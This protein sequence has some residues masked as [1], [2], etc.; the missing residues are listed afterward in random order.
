MAAA[1]GMRCYLEA[2]GTRNKALYEHLGYETVD[3][4]GLS[5]KETVDLGWPGQ[6][7]FYALVRDIETG[8]EPVP[9]QS[10]VLTD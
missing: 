6:A 7:Q 4:R 1:D 8:V 10:R 9:S 3:Q 5:V 2:S